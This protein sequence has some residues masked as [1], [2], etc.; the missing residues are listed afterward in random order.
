MPH[1]WLEFALA[2]YALAMFFAV[3]SLTGLAGKTTQWLAPVMGVGALF[4]FV[5]LLETSIQNGQLAPVNPAQSES[6][7]AFLLV[8]VFL[9]VY[10]FYK[11]S[12]H[13]VIIA[14]IVFL[15]ALASALSEKQPGVT[16]GVSVPAIWIYLH[17][18]MIFAGYAAL[19]L[20]FVSSVFYLVQERSLKTKNMG[21]LASRMPALAVLDD[22]SGKTLQAGFPFMTVGLA[23]GVMIGFMMEGPAPFLDSKVILSTLMWILYVFLLFMRWKAGVRGRNA[24]V[25][26][27]FATLLAASSWAA[28]YL[29]VMSASGG[30]ALKP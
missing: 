18:A 12:T 28:H 22:I 24:A 6:A 17:I 26:S 15:L 8:A 20:S 10:G 5:S 19:F 7:L 13:G 30:G 1:L 23:L 9:L 27:L 29:S 25:L 21:G 16:L 3:A 2:L 14:P 4:H 11:T